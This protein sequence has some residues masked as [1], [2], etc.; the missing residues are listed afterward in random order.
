VLLRIVNL[1]LLEQWFSWDASHW[2]DARYFSLGRE[3]IWKYKKISVFSCQVYL[4]DEQGQKRIHGC[5]NLV[6]P[7]L[8]NFL[9]L[10]RSRSLNFNPLP[11]IFTQS[12][13]IPSW[14]S[15]RFIWPETKPWETVTGGLRRNSTHYCILLKQVRW[16]TWPSPTSSRIIDEK[17]EKNRASGSLWDVG[18][19]RLRNHV[20]EWFVDRRMWRVWF[21]KGGFKREYVHFFHFFGL[22]A[23][24]EAVWLMDL[25]VE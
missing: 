15:C 23:I 13:L 11:N 7:N 25:V 4:I 9:R 16:W 8:K 6:G 10:R 21:Q 24:T 12:C 20:L 22:S 18:R 3:V 5:S 1:L 19:E 14:A 17:V 2:W